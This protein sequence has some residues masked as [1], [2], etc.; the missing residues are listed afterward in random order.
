M[1]LQ[2]TCNFFFYFNI[3][4]TYKYTPLTKYFRRLYDI[5][6]V[7]NSIHA[8]RKSR[9]K[10]HA[11][12]KI[13]SNVHLLLKLRHKVKEIWLGITQKP[14]QHRLSVPV[15]YVAIDRNIQMVF[16]EKKLRKPLF[17]ADCWFSQ[18]QSGCRIGAWN[19]Y[20]W[21]PYAVMRRVCIQINIF[22]YGSQ[23]PY[24]PWLCVA[25]HCIALYCTCIEGSNPRLAWS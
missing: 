11:G 15:V 14:H 5:I 8:A 10:V 1:L 9:Q 3:A 24:V 12:N 6:P 7:F 18:M 20:T 16:I 2:F 4:K 21:K 19:I 22:I 23:L 17:I 13:R 25:F